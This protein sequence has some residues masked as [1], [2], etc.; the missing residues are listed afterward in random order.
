LD[1][2]ARHRAIRTEYAA[3]ALKGL[4]GLPAALAQV[5]E[6]AS[7]R[8]HLF[9]SLMAAVGAGNGGLFDHVVEGSDWFGAGSIDTT[10]Y[11]GT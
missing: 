9:N 7:I 1:G 11:P 8:R 2:R 3:I 10:S 5:E 6:L 4:Q